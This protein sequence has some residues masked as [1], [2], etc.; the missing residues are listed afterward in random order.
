MAY[1][2]IS[3]QLRDDVRSTIHHKKTKE[4]ALLVQPSRS[5]FVNI[6]EPWIVDVTWKE[7]KNLL[8]LMPTDWVEFASDIRIKLTWDRTLDNGETRNGDTYV[9]LESRG[10]RFP[11]PPGTSPYTPSFKPSPELMMVAPKEI[12]DRLGELKQWTIEHEDIDRRWNK[13]I[14][15]VDNFLV[16]CKSLNEAIKL[17]PDL[18]MYIP[19]R[20]LEKAEE[21]SQKVKAA[22][23]RALE[24]LKQIDTDGAVASA[25]MLRLR[26]ATN[27]PGEVA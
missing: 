14:S 18:R 12:A 1:V 21:K 5:I 17:W 24:V 16:S 26:E 3:Q 20:F 4:L 15:D 27:I 8:P 7:H 6:D 11:L 2:A 19:G 9:Q 23:S 22:E 13:V 25:V 10:G